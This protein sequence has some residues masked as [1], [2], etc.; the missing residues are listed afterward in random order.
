MCRMRKAEFMKHAQGPDGKHVY[1]SMEEVRR[2]G[3][4]RAQSL[5]G[6]LVRGAISPGTCA[7]AA[8]PRMARVQNLKRMAR[9]HGPQRQAREHGPKRKARAH[10]PKRKAV[11]IA[12]EVARTWILPK[13]WLWICLR[14]GPEKKIVSS[15]KAC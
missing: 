13:I 10:D 6:P 4:G 15:G 2:D 9:G 11:E 7:S 1:R 5:A 12:A 14:S 8:T 3:A